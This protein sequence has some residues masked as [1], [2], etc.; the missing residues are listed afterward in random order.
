MYLDDYIQ[1][2]EQIAAEHKDIKKFFRANDNELS[3]ALRNQMEYPVLVLGEYDG[4]LMES[5]QRVRY[6]DYMTPGIYLLD[7]IPRGDYNAEQQKLNRLKAIGLQIFGRLKHDKEN[8]CPRY[9]ID[10][11]K[12][13][14]KYSLTDFMYENVRGWL[15]EFTVYSTASE[16]VYNPNDWNFS[17]PENNS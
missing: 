5:T 12:D 10:W 16:L 2:W 11:Q 7:I 15:F 17:N 6:L 9:F 4:K 3:D 1:I 8:I 14:I 13:P